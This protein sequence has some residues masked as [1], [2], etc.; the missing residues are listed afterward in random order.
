MSQHYAIYCDESCHLEQDGQPIMVLGAV[1]CPQEK[2]REIAVRIR[3]LK[4]R[5]GLSSTFEI[6]WAKVSPAKVAFYRDVLDYFF[7]DDDLH[8]RALIVANKAKLRHE[9]FEQDHDTWYYKMYFDLLVASGKI[10]PEAAAMAAKEFQTA[11]ELAK[12]KS[13]F[14]CHG[15]HMCLRFRSPSTHDV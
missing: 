14:E 2:T 12:E 4:Q 11:P 5:H 8:F 7:D 15:A 1:W 3:E 13:A 6:K 9:D 10:R